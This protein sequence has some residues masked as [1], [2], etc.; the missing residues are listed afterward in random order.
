MSIRRIVPNIPCERVDESRK[1]YTEFLG[2][3]VAMDMGWIVTL[4]SP[5][6][7]TAQVSLLPGPGSAAPQA[8]L[9]LTVEVTDVD[10]VHARAATCDLPIVYPLTTEPWGV[11]RFGVTDPNGVVINVMS[12]L[13]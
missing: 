2:L 8:P 6:N 1:F 3:D 9:S 7:P 11:R 10:A 5:R 4:A 13:K 12:H